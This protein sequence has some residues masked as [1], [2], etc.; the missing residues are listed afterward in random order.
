MA[1]TAE[2][3]RRLVFICDTRSPSEKAH[4]YHSIKSCEAFAECG[5]DVAL[6]LPR[7]H[8]RRDS[9]GATEIFDYYGLPPTFSVRILPNVDVVR[10]ER[11]LPGPV[12]RGSY[13]ARTM[14]WSAGAA[15]EAR[16][17]RA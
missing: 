13:W 4:A 3:P 17:A 15:V 10:W 5:L 2:P 9:I 12:L 11:Q 6:W 14:A 1:T 8:R 7:R 16:R